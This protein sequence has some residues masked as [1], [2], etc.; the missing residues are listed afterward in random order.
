L[1]GSRARF[2]DDGASDEAGAH[3]IV[4]GRGSGAR[5]TPG[6]GLNVSR[7][8][9]RDSSLTTCEFFQTKKEFAQKKSVRRFIPA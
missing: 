1:A 6:T 9:V 5:G 7:T 4:A 2:S 3:R 8:V